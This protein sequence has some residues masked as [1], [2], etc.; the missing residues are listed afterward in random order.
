[1]CTLLAGPSAASS[2][3]SAAIVRA[4][5]LG[6]LLP[7]RPGSA[8]EAFPQSHPGLA[9]FTEWLVTASVAPS[10]NPNCGCSAAWADSGQCIF[11]HY[12]NE[13][14]GGTTPLT[15]SS[16]PEAPWCANY[17]GSRDG[18][19][20]SNYS[21]LVGQ[22][23]TAFLVDRF[24]EFLQRRAESAA[25]PPLLALLWLH[26]VH[27]PFVATAAA[28]AACA[29]G[30]TCLLPPPPPPGAP[31]PQLKLEWATGSLSAGCDL[32]GWPRNTSFAAARD[33]CAGSAECCG[34]AFEAPFDGSRTPPSGIRTYYLKRA[35]TTH[36]RAR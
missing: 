15:N 28:K 36:R 24:V 6:N 4:G 25:P 18:A 9:G 29:K 22:D 32:E 17:W 35:P 14:R 13:G 5:H 11:G 20:V 34:M 10:A 7:D 31:P 30:E 8:G 1:M 2:D 3:R 16:L 26:A 27:I 19:Q 21:S 23:D 12:T 33:A